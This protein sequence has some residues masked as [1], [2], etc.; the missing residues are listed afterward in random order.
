MQARAEA[1][2]KELAAVKER[3]WA[4]MEEK[5]SQLQA[6]RV[7]PCILTPLILTSLSQLSCLN[8]H[9]ASFLK[10]G[11]FLQAVYSWLQWYRESL[12]GCRHRRTMLQRIPAELSPHSHSLTQLQCPLCR[13]HFHTVAKSPMAL[14]R[15]RRAST[16]ETPWYRSCYCLMK[17]PKCVRYALKPD[18]LLNWE[19]IAD[20]WHGISGRCQLGC[21]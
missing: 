15:A 7:G 11:C 2:E 17:C 16:M 20:V 3:A 19:I 4:L 10:G 8:L 21:W 1:A 13:P 18:A 14:V 5:D 12:Y 6:A 9:V